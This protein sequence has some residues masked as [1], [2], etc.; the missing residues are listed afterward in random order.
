MKLD[1]QLNQQEHDTCRTIEIVQSTFNHST[2]TPDNF[3][4]NGDEL[5]TPP[6][7]FS[8]VDNGIFRS[9]F[10]DAANFSFIKTLGLRSIVYVPFLVVIVKRLLM[11]IRKL[12]HLYRG[13]NK[14]HI[15]V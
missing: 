9:G 6:L 7:N 1:Q 3:D 5:Y 10:P 4:S 14:F 8:M 11:W 12:S 15:K 13:P 2:M